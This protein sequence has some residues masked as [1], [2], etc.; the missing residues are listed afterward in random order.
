MGL[1]R[2]ALI[3]LPFA[4]GCGD[5][6]RYDDAAA[7][8]D[9]R[10]QDGPSGSPDATEV[11][12]AAA[13]APV[14]A[15]GELVAVFRDFRIDHPD[16]EPPTVVDDRGLVA[17]ELGRDDK[18]VYAPGGPTP[19]V[20]GADSFSQW[21]R[22]VDG[23]NLRFE[24]PVVL[25]PTETGLYSFGDD[26]FFPLDGLGWPGEEIDGHNYHFT[27]EI[28]GTFRYDGGE[29]FTFTGDDDVFL[30]INGRLALDLG[31][32]HGAET[33]AID[34]DAQSAALGISHGGVY[35]LD[36]FHAERHTT[37]STF[38]VETTID[39]LH[40]TGG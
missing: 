28:H 39:C 35:H 1:R 32:V 13:D 8:A 30:F 33:G 31:G 22:D 40:A 24:Q 11:D 19:T 34:L 7:P 2:C 4:A 5:V 16:F 29:Q 36:V 21:Y 15:C 20:S 38:H 9:A 18:P 37:Q 3:L 6:V 23:V 12:G 25:T 17:F 10:S 27:T 26:T 14:A